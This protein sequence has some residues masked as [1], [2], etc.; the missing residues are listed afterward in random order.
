MDSATPASPHIPIQHYIPHDTHTHT[1]LHYTQTTHKCNSTT[2]PWAKGFLINVGGGR[3]E[4]WDA[5]WLFLATPTASPA[6]KKN[7]TFFHD[8]F[9]VN[10]S[11]IKT[12]LIEWDS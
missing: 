5:P 10:I 4:G 3:G 8:D 11:K 12:E 9:Y 6:Q 2:Y 1:Q 7:D